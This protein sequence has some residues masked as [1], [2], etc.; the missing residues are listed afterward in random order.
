MKPDWLIWLGSAALL[1]LTM[2]AVLSL[3][4]VA[5]WAMI[6]IGLAGL[7]GSVAM[8]MWAERRMRRRHQELARADFCWCPHCLYD[9][10]ASDNPSRC[11]ECGKEMDLPRI[12]AC[13][14]SLGPPAP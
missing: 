5:W 12:C 9:L 14:K 10:S 13:W 1:G 7:G 3:V 4:F 2:L 8:V 6:I 11:P